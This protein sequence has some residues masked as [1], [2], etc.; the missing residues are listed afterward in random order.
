MADHQGRAGTARCTGDRLRYLP[1]YDEVRT[2]DTWFIPTKYD[3]DVLA[4]ERME[5]KPVAELFSD[6]YRLQN[7][8]RL[9]GEEH[10]KVLG[11]IIKELEEKPHEAH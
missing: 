6:F 11:K 7:N 2:D 4:A 10:M 5:N 8:D 9:P 3:V 1:Q